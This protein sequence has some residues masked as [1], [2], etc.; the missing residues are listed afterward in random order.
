LGYLYLEMFSLNREIEFGFWKGKQ[1]SPNAASNMT[2]WQVLVWIPAKLCRFTES[3]KRV[4]ANCTCNLDE[5][6]A[7][8]S[9]KCLDHVQKLV[10][11][12]IKFRN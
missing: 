6:E 11:L 12:S 4:H 8:Y 7:L 2:G 9:L 10:D 3:W 5:E 1:I